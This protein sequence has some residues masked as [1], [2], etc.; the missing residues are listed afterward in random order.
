MLAKGAALSQMAWS[1][2]ASG[3]DGTDCE[4][5]VVVVGRVKTGIGGGG[6]GLS[7]K[8]CHYGRSG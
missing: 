3:E 8:K 2:R 1:S 6:R 4:E 7:D 5:E